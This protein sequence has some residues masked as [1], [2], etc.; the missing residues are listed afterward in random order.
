[1]ACLN[2]SPFEIEKQDNRKTML[3]KRSRENNLPIIYLNAVGGRMIW[4]L[5]AALWPSNLTAALLMK[6]RAL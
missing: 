2:A 4:Y 5:T 3:A 1:M 6:R